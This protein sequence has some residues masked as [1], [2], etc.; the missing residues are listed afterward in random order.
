MG[1][2]NPEEAWPYSLA[3]TRTT[4]QVSPEE[5]E[6]WNWAPQD[7]RGGSG[8]WKEEWNTSWADVIAKEMKNVKVAFAII[9]CHMISD[10]KN[11]D[12]WSKA[13]LVAVGLLTE[14][15]KCLT[16]SSVVSCETVCLALTLPA[17]Y[18]LEVKSGNVLNAYVTAPIT[19]KVWIVLGSEWGRQAGK[20]PLLFVPYAN[21]RVQALCCQCLCW[22][23]ICI[24][25]W[26]E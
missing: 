8:T 22:T 15:P 6:I 9:R 7:C 18:D 14:T 21:W 11:E 10:V 2:T 23:V 25:L 20:K 4:D 24:W 13:S 1:K 5:C 12:S 3:C 17:L 19:K 16:Y 26:W